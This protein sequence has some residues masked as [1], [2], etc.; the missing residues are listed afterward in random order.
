M[1]SIA[2]EP[3]ARRLNLK[4]RRRPCLK[5]GR[6]FVTTR[7]KRLCD[8]CTE[9]NTELGTPTAVVTQDEHGRR[10]GPTYTPDMLAEIGQ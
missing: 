5:C 7:C 2:V 8:A 10:Q 4:L 9:E 1:S 3:S 6:K